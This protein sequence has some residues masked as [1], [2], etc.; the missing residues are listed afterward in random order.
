MLRTTKSTSLICLLALALL[1][2]AGWAAPSPQ[3]EESTATEE[4]TET[5]AEEA[6]ATEDEEGEAKPE[7]ATSFFEA[8]TVTAT[9][10]KADVFSIA[11]PV[12]VISEEEI[13]RKLP[14]NAVDLFRSQPGVDV[15]GVGPNQARPIIR[16]QR[17]L[18][19]LFME[20]GL[21]LN[22]ARRQSDFGEISGL[23]DMG[24]VANVEVLR[25]PA[26]VLY[27]TDAIGGVLNLVT[28][29]PVY[30]DGSWTAGSLD[31]GYAD[32]SEGFR[33]Q[34]Y[35]QGRQQKWA[36]NLGATY[37]DSEDYIAAGG[38]YGDIDLPDDTPVNDT[39]LQDDSVYGFLSY[40]FTD[41][42]LLSF[43]FNRYRAGETGFGWVDPILL[44]ELDRIQILYPY[45]DFNR[46]TMEYNASALQAAL[47][48]TV[49]VNLLYQENQ[50][51]LL[52]NIDAYS[53]FGGPG[54]FFHIGVNTE[55][56][57]DLSTLG[58]RAEASKILG[59][60][61]L[62]S[63][64]GEYYDD[65]S[66]NTDSSYTYGALAMQ[67]DPAL[68]P[69]DFTPPFFEVESD[70]ANTPNARNVAWGLF[71][72]DQFLIGSRFSGTVGVRYANTDTKAKE[73]P[74]LD[75]AG[76]DFSDDDIVGAVSAVYQVTDNLNLVG[77]YGTAFRAPN[78]VER[79]FNG[80]TPEGSGYQ[81]LNPDLKSEQ[82]DNV[83]LGLKYRRM[84]AVFELMV[85]RN[86][87]KDGIV[88]EFLSDEEIAQLPPDVQ[89]DIENSGASVVVQ[90][91]NASKLRYRGVEAM[92]GWRADNGVSIGANYTYLDAE[93]VDTG[94]PTGDTY[95]DKINF[96]TRYDRPTGRYWVEYRLRHNGSADAVTDPD[97]PIPAVGETLPAFTIHTLSGGVVLFERARQQHSLTLVIDNFTDELYSE[98]SNA[99]FFRPQAKRNFLV[100]Y[101]LRI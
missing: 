81:I 42:Q 38:R 3:Q 92:I 95:K 97:A 49:R 36:F 18:R 63:Y 82:S 101:R 22:N 78:I 65:D 71:A 41:S 10:S 98:F 27:G 23:I 88:Q 12:A 28:K 20:N 69:E 39:G 50:R 45:Q 53:P 25:G 46:Y 67:M 72:Q 54:M 75:T 93:R 35:V 40:D 77:S 66:F 61:H 94:A 44:G 80:L 99:S 13:G 15:N 4:A 89:E 62:L 90:Q 84:N 57:T 8:T 73:T 100:S 37:R 26:S 86:E 47:A 59:E 24:S 9:G 48:N 60:N 85:F 55:N 14:E 52:N 11:T 56:F 6:S 1:P 2:V 19:V 33:A 64:G 68:P 43:R 58:L 91:Q 96:Y 21:R 31:L 70:T 5:A 83:D 16:G 17:G 87:I 34:G 30:G 7:P 51:E 32:A 79:L 74:G 29:S 76:L